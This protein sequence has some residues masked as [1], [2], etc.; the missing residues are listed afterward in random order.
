MNPANFAINKN[1]QDAIN[2]NNQQ[3]TTTT[4]SFIGAPLAVGSPSYPLLGE[5]KN[6]TYW[7]LPMKY[8]GLGLGVAFVGAMVIDEASDG[9]FPLTMLN[10][11]ALIGSIPLSKFLAK[12]RVIG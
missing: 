9:H 3:S 8:K 6:R 11:A 4:D 7:E 1:L 5:T 2:A 10:I 12:G